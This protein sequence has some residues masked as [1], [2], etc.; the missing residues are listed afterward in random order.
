MPAEVQQPVAK[1]APKLDAGTELAVQRTSMAADR[2]MMAWIRTATSLITFGFT[3]YKFFT[4]DKTHE[5][6]HPPIVSARTFA[7]IMIIA[8]LGTLVIA[9]VDHLQTRRQLQAQYGRQQ[10]FYAMYLAAVIAVLGFAALL[11]VLLRQ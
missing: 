4:L 2:T 8:G 3:I 9:T 5:P 7:L 11:S 6:A 1:T 10:H